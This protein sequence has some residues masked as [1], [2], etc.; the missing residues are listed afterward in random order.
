MDRTE[1]T[2]VDASFSKRRY[3]S[4]SQR[5]CDFCRSRKVACR[6]E[7]E[8]PCKLCKSYN[9]LC[10]FDE[11][12]KPRKKTSATCQPQDGPRPAEVVCDTVPSLQPGFGTRED[13]TM[14]L[15]LNNFDDSIGIFAQLDAFTPQEDLFESTGAIG[16]LDR[17]PSPFRFDEDDN[18]HMHSTAAMTIGTSSPSKSEKTCIPPNA[19]IQLCG[20]TGDMDPS[21]LSQYRYDMHDIHYFKRLAIHSVCDGIHPISFLV[22]LDSPSPKIE[23]RERAELNRI[24]DPQIGT[25]L[26]ELQVLSQAFP[27]MTDRHLDFISSSSRNTLFSVSLVNPHPL[28]PLHICSLLF[29]HSPNDFPALTIICVFRSCTRVFPASD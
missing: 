2:M 10:T 13:M 26:I 25:R 23:D 20:L 15:E 3:M 22:P 11:P 7:A 27:S 12:A 28:K 17:W 1:G 6:I 24:V 29:T 4:K 16:G 19:A 14:P 18:D 9:R 5:A 8:L 21:V